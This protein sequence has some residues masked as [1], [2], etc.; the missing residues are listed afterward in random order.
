MLPSH[1][2]LELGIEYN[3]SE[4][5][6]DV[7]LAGSYQTSGSFEINIPNDRLEFSKSQLH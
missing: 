4:I 2:E 1:Y 6:N 3:D 5:S 7:E